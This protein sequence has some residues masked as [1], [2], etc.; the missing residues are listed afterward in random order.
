MPSATLPYSINALAGWYGF[1]AGGL[2]GATLGL[3]FHRESWLG[4]YGSF[5]RRFFRLGHIACFGL[6]LINLLFALTVTATGDAGDAGS[7]LLIVALIT[8][9][10]TC[11][12]T[13]LR[14]GFRHLFFVPVGATLGGIVLTLVQL[15]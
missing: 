5:E 15:T 3:F 6:G 8:M 1:L 4:G 9:P 11:V 13:A 14:R 2:T 10:A 12:L 7:A